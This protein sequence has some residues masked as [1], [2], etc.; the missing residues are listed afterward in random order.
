MS[1]HIDPSSPVAF[2]GTGVMGRSM[3]GHLLRAGYSLRVHNRTASKAQEL[4][5]AGARWCGSVAE[6]VEGAGVVLTM[7]GFPRDVE[8]TYF[9]SSGILENAGAGALLVDMTTS[10]PALAERIARDA[11]ERGMLS[12]DAPVSGGDVGARDGRLVFMVGG[13]P[14]AFER[15]QPIFSQMGKTVRH[16]GSAGAGQ[17]CKIANQV[18]V[19]VGMVAWCESLAYAQAAGLDPARVQETIRDGAAGSWALSQLAPRALSG[20]FAPGFYIK[21]MLKDLEI[22]L[23][24][25][26]SFGVAVPGLAAARALF[27]RAAARGWEECGTQALYRLYVEREQAD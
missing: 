5:D 6:A 7:L 3:A 9:G 15:A 14:R 10:S 25:A 21:H 20:D 12:L 8:S 26:E 18:A 2:I 1:E 24:A 22:A 16:L 4:V 19:A 27:A 17:H 23:G 11:D 13:D